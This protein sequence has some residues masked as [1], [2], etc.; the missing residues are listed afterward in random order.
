[1]PEN[2]ETARLRLMGKLQDREYY[3]LLDLETPEEIEQSIDREID[4][5]LSR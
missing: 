1:M 2:I 3:E 4:I 5:I